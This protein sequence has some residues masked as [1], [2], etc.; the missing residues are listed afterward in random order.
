MIPSD[1][2]NRL[3]VMKIHV[4]NF[5]DKIFKILDDPETYEPLKRSRQTAIEKQ[6]NKVIKGVLK[7]KAYSKSDLEKLL[8]TGSKPAAFQAFLKDHKENND[9]FPLRP[10]A[11]VRNTAIEKVDW[12]VSKILNHLVNHVPSNIKNTTELIEKIKSIEVRELNPSFT[13]VSLD[14][15]I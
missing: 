13:F 11:S 15:V 2:T 4:D 6:A 5:E 14:V 9:G 3:V 8:T 10:I 12:L 1:K 7:D